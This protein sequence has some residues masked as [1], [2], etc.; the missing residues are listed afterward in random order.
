MLPYIYRIQLHLSRLRY[1]DE[2]LFHC[3]AS[4]AS[5]LRNA[6]GQLS[7][8][9]NKVGGSSKTFERE[10]ESRCAVVDV[11]GM[12]GLLWRSLEIDASILG[13]D[14][15]VVF[16]A[17]CHCDGSRGARYGVTSLIGMTLLFPAPCQKVEVSKSSPGFISGTL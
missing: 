6:G 3:E 7:C 10:F 2:P 8:P 5:Q 1:T 11:E 4:L 12:Y 9:C 14:L 13:A 17:V 15:G 16:I